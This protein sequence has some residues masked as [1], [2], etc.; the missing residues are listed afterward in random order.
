MPVF[1]FT[2]SIAA[3]ASATP[4]NTPIPWQYR[5]PP[6][7]ALIELMVNATATG[8]VMNFTTGAESIVQGESPVQAGGVVGVMPARLNVEPIVDK[9]DAGEELS[10]LLRN[11]TA[12]AIT[13]NGIIV[14]TYA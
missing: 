3:G 10:L 13:V 6:R 8:I 14:M 7:P 1:T 12:G 5:F 4:L 9:V 11:T 2:Q